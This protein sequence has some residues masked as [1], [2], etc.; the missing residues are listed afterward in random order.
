MVGHPLSLPLSL[1][2]SLCVSL[3]L[4]PSLVELLLDAYKPQIGCDIKLSVQSAYK[5]LFNLKTF[6]KLSDKT[7]CSVRGRERES[8]KER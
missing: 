6:C 5:F 8:T 7:D 1:S 3:S 4:L 2:F